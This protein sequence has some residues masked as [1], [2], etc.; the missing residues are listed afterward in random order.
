M[1]TYRF[2]WLDGRETMA[3]GHSMKE[4]Y[5]TILTKRSIKQLLTV[6]KIG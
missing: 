6:K 3:R 2:I 4:A 5:D 1:S